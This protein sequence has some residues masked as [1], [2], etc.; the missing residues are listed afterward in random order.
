MMDLGVDFD[1]LVKVRFM[2]GWWFFQ[3]GR[4]R[5]GLLESEP[6]VSSAMKLHFSNIDEREILKPQEFLV[7]LCTDRAGEPFR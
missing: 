4:A 1:I 3:G 2:F 7:I 5:K 6:K